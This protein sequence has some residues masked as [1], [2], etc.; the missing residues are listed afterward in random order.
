V[1]AV[2][3]SLTGIPA[4]GRH[5]ASPGERDRPQGFTVDLEVEVEAEG[6]SLEGT[7]D[8]RRMAEVARATVAGTS[9]ELLESLAR[10][11][12]EAVVGLDRVRTVTA[13]VHKPAAARSVGASDVAARATLGER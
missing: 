8:Y 3:I 2:R 11:V 6:D 13:T 4:E 5:G 9:F 1:G 7:A 12:A 10:A